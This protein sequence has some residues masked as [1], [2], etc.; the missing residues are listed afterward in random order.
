MKSLERYFCCPVDG[1]KIKRI[2]NGVVCRI[3]GR[4][5]AMTKEGIF[6][7]LVEEESIKKL[8]EH[9]KNW[10]KFSIENTNTDEY[11]RMID[12]T[13]FERIYHN[14]RISNYRSIIDRYLTKKNLIILDIGASTGY[15]KSIYP[16]KRELFFALDINMNVL[17]R[18]YRHVVKDNSDEILVRGDCYTLPFQENS[19]DLITMFSV[20]HRLDGKRAFKE[21]ARVLKP[22][23]FFIVSTP[24]KYFPFWNQQIRKFFLD[25]GIYSKSKEMY[26]SLIKPIDRYE[27]KDLAN[28]STKSL[29]YLNSFIPSH[30]AEIVSV[31]KKVIS[32]E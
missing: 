2:D 27:R 19:L 23:G 18:R 31:Y 24:W 4:K 14:L 26:S 7:F 10:R 6:D 3:C 12:G 20:F 32:H 17:K 29:I 13:F 15:A 30:L 5:Y 9:Y 22:D 11:H 25:I 8:S 1:G 28:Y 21:I 16:P